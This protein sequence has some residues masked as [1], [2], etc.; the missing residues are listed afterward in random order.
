M[1][2][3]TAF[4]ATISY[5]PGPSIEG[6]VT[7]LPLDEFRRDLALWIQDIQSSMVE[8]KLSSSLAPDSPAGIA[9]QKVRDL[10]DGLADGFFFIILWFCRSET[11]SM[12]VRPAKL[13]QCRR[14]K[15]VVVPFSA[16]YPFDNLLRAFSR[17]SSSMAIPGS[18][19]FWE[20]P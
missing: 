11:F 19:P 14:T 5:L 20:P 1:L 16:S 18:R 7:F 9:C 15:Y 3:C 12:T 10:S 17:Q 4:S 2:A 13:R 6:E 8:G